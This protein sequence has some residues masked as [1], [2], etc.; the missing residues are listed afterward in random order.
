MINSIITEHLAD[1][2]D[3]EGVSLWDIN[4]VHYSA[5]ITLLEHEGKLHEKRNIRKRDKPGWQI[6]LEQRIDSTRR[7]LAFVN[8][9]LRCKKEGRYTQHQRNTERKL[10]KWYG[11]TTKENLEKTETTLKQVKNLRTRKWLM[12]EKL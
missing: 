8:L 2:H 11:R 4:I 12:K 3:R 10:R 6:Q 5:A 7:R 9:I 1:V